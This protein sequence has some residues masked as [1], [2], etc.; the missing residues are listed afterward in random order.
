[1]NTKLKLSL[2]TCISQCFLIYFLATSEHVTRY[3]MLLLVFWE[4]MPYLLYRAQDVSDEIVA[5]ISR[6]GQ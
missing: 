2:L 4:V 6:I 5:F 1:M 3:Y